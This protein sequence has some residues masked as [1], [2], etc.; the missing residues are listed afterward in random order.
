MNLSSSPR[1]LV[2]LCNFSWGWATGEDS[3]DISG[4]AVV[5]VTCSGTVEVE[6]IL[7]AFRAGMDGVLI[8]A[9]PADECHFL[10]GNAQAARRVALL[11]EVLAGNGIDPLRLSLLNGNDP[12]GTSVPILVRE[13]WKTVAGLGGSYRKSPGMQGSA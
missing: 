4:C 9:C 5:P 2:F 11:R 7:T 1:I 8:L 12:S 10:D 3:P 6:Q 13:F